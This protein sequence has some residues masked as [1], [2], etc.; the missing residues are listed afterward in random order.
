[1]EIYDHNTLYGNV[2]PDNRT[3][4]LPRWVLAVLAV[5]CAAVVALTVVLTV[6]LLRLPKQQEPLLPESTAELA[7]RILPSVT[8][9][10][11]S[12]TSGSGVVVDIRGGKAYIVT[13]FHVVIGNRLEGAPNPDVRF[14]GQNDYGQAV[15]VGY[16]AYH[17]IALLVADNPP[18][19][20][21]AAEW[22][23]QVPAV[24][25]R[26]F[27]AG[28]DMGKGV[29]FYEGLLSNN[30]RM[31]KTDS[32]LQGEAE[33]MGLPTKSVPVLQVSAP[34][35]AGMS[36]GGLFGADGKL[37]GINTY[38]TRTI[39][40]GGK[41]TPVEN[42]GYSV[43]AA[44]AEGVCKNILQGQGGQIERLTVR[45]AVR[46]DAQDVAA[47]GNP[48]IDCTALRFT[49]VWQGEGLTVLSATEYQM[50]GPLQVGD[51]IVEFGG[52]P[53]GKLPDYTAPFA[54]VLCYAYDAERKTEPLRLV[55]LRAQKREEIRF[56][57]ICQKA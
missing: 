55:V 27:T 46:G 49:A 37:L 44:I 39:G 29:A 4:R 48:I 34:I 13:N 36:G 28:N 20:I 30:A 17:D 11:G 52:R 15:I 33:G 51:V 22:G 14:Y 8:E 5:L 19:G 43:P 25:T 45:G 35:N 23:T 1:M 7:A 6:F 3:P 38:Q 12:G 9:I 21:A 57:A 47:N 2:P 18:A 50:S 10:R 53:I 56:Y 41:A 32:L 26:I 40:E 42:V 24:G 16:D 54:E 31:L